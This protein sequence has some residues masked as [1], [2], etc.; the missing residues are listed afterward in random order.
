MKPGASWVLLLLAL[1]VPAVPALAQEVLPGYTGIYNNPDVDIFD[2]LTVPQERIGQQR[3][4]IYARYGRPFVT[5]TYRAFFSTKPWYREKPAFTEAWLT[6]REREL[7][8]GLLRLEKPAM[9]PS[10]YRQALLS[11][12]Q[13]QLDESRTLLLLG[14]GFGL[15]VSATSRGYS[16]GGS[17]GGYDDSY[18]GY[19]GSPYGGYG[20]GY[21]FQEETVSWTTVGDWLVISRNIAGGYVILQATLPDLRTGLCGT[22]HVRQDAYELATKLGL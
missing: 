21:G 12:G 8:Q 6:P 1:S 16:Y 19:Y 15:V 7:A 13:F 18:G 4:E 3:N 9:A 14:E 10:Q 5:E 20:D 22:I 2:F 11:L 17:Y